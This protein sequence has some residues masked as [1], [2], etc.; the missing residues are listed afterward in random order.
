LLPEDRVT[1]AAPFYSAEDR[2]GVNAHGAK[3]TCPR[4]LLE[5]I[6][7]IVA[8]GLIFTFRLPLDNTISPKVF[9]L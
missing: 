3:G 9:V 2:A 6:S 7:S 8:A 5:V 1:S 4:T